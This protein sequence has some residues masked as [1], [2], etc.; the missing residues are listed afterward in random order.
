MVINFRHCAQDSKSEIDG[1]IRIYF[2]MLNTSILNVSL[3]MMIFFIA[4]D[5]AGAI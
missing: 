2:S 4:Q 5:R 1:I 3:C